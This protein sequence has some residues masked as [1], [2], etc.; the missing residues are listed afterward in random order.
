MRA[1]IAAFI[2]SVAAGPAAA[3]SV[4]AY[5]PSGGTADSIRIMRC[6]ACGTAT[7]ATPSVSPIA[8]A[9]DR[10]ELRDID[11]DRKVVRTDNLWGGSPVTTITSAALVFG[12]DI[13]EGATLFAESDEDDVPDTV[14]ADE[15]TAAVKADAVSD[16]F[17]KEKLRGQ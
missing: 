5:V 12:D 6:E 15:T 2:L 1:L 14:D 16:L 4:G 8:G 9:V 3:Q 7:A 13:P 11:G 10:R 17:G